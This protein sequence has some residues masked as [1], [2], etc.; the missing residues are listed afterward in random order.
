MGVFIGSAVLSIA[1]K[2][3]WPKAN[4]I[5]AIRGTT[6]GCILGIIIWLS[7]ASVEYGKV[8]LDT[9]G[10]NAPMLAGNLVSILTGGA[11]RAV[12]SFLW[13]Q[14]YDWDTTKQI[15]MVE[16]EKSELLVEEFNKEKLI[17]ATAWIVK[18]GVG[19][20]VVI[21]LLW[22]LLSLPAG[23]FSEGYFTF[24]AIIAIAWGTVGS[25]VIIVFPL[26][27]S[28]QTIRSVILGMFTNDRLMEKVKELNLKLHTIMFA[29]PE[30]ERNYLLEKD[31][32]P[33]IALVPLLKTMK[34][35]CKS[36]KVASGEELG[37]ELSIEVLDFSEDSKLY[38]FQIP[39]TAKSPNRMKNGEEM[40]FLDL[41]DQQLP[42]VDVIDT[43]NNVVSNIEENNIVATSTQQQCIINSSQR[44]QRK[45]RI[46]ISLEVFQQRFVMKLDDAAQSLGSKLTYLGKTVPSYILGKIHILLRACR[47]YNIIWWPPH[48]RNKDNHLLSNKLIQGAVQEQIREPSQPPISDPPHKNTIANR[49]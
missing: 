17:R 25:A 8:N 43:G 1:F 4:A 33:R 34:Q 26:T 42:E 27:E 19:F 7:V 22:P 10:R 9:T 11:I 35:D 20:T 44:P 6:I 3:L 29:I 12:C 2:L 36:L 31:G 45:A 23:Q 14:N 15:T 16:K 18:W 30:A 40:V 41:S 37:E 21:V 46:P 5:G 32:D 13:P 48:K 49:Y 38:S 39:Q 24:W 47:E 28:W